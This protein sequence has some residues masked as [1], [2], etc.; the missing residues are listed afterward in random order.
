M[1]QFKLAVLVIAAL[2]TLVVVNTPITHAAFSDMWADVYADTGKIN[3]RGEKELTKI[4]S[5]ITYQVLAVGADTEE[6][7]YVYNDASLTAYGNVVT[8][9]YFNV[10]DRVQFRVDPTDSTNDRYVDLIVTNTAGGYTAFVE[11]FDKYTHTIVIDQRPNVMHHGCIPILFNNNVETDTG[12]DFDYD[13]LIHFVTHEVVTVDATE[14]ID[15]GTLSTGTDG[16]ANGFIAAGL[17]S[18]A[19]YPL[20]TLA[21]SGALMDNATNFDPDGHY[22]ISATEQSLTY[23]CSAGSDTFAGYIHYFFTRMR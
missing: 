22:I 4:T 18:V 12:I 7:L 14:T 11:D 21:L 2:L 13:T 8:T 5:G 23:T 3:A 10:V 6:T 9:T 1:K 20:V 15:I 19:G 17:T 16:D